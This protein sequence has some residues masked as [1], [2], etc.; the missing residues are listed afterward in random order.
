MLTNL[1]RKH[2]AELVTR[3]VSKL[4]VLI[5]RSGKACH[6]LRGREIVFRPLNKDVL[7]EG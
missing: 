5:D 2:V 7:S 1:I 3:V 4:I 6:E